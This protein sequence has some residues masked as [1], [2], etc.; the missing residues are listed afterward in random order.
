M[1]R[2]WE[3]ELIN[4]L[5]ELPEGYSSD[6]ASTKKI[7]WHTISFQRG[8]TPEMSSFGRCYGLMIILN[9][10]PK[11][12]TITEFKN[13][14]NTNGFIAIILNGKCSDDG[15]SSLSGMTKIALY[16]YNTTN[17]LFKIKYRDPSTNNIGDS[18]YF[19]IDKGWSYFEDLGANAIN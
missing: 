9:N 17:N 16:I 12:I 8:G 3:T 13:L 1:K 14:L 4:K 18:D 10:S 15:G 5:K 7:Y 2:M 19:T 11:P 6:D